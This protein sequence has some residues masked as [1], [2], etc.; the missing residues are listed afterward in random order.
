[1]LKINVI[2]PFP[3]MFEGIINSSILLKGKQKGIV[4]YNIIN[5]FDYLDDPNQRID[6]YPY[7]G[8]EG[9]ILKP[10]PLANAI[11]SI[12]EKGNQKIIFPTPD[13]ELFNHSKAK[14]FSNCDSLV[15]ICGHYKGIDQRI[16]DNFVT[17]EISIGDFV[18]TSGELP[19][20]LMMDSII[21][22]KKG[23]LNN[24]VSAVNDSFYDLLLDGPHFT[25]P[26]NFRSKSVPD[27]LLSGNHKKIEKWFLNK[28]EEK[29]KKRRIDLWKKYRSSNNNGVK[30][31]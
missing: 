17:D 24:Y 22:L 20:M 26:R 3:E 8:G 12:K 2:T 16:R 19:A 29:T 10:E 23:V 25:R 27:I 9:M 7:G 30:N 21:R 31:G 11:E 18:L 28:R 15:F 13:G 14:E 5:L 4:S 1:M 6:D